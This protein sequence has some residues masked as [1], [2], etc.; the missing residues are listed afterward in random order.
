MGI[1]LIIFILIALAI[2][3][4]GALAYRKNQKRIE[5]DADK[6]RNLKL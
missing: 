6:L 4:G 2:L 5:E 3:V 1:K